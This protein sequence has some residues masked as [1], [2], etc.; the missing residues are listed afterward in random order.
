MTFRAI[1]VLQTVLGLALGA[2]TW[3]LRNTPTARRSRALR[4]VWVTGI[5]LTAVPIAVWQ[6]PAGPD[7]RRV[8]VVSVLDEETSRALAEAFTRETGI[9]CDIDPFAGGAQST[10]E[11]ISQGRIHP[12]VLLGGTV[13]I[14]EELAKTGKLERFTPPPDPARVTRY[15]DPI[16][17]WTP[18]YLGYLCLVYRPLPDLQA[19]PPE[20]LTLI[21]PRWKGRVAIPSPDQSGGGLVF[22]AT[23]LLRQTDPERGWEYMELLRENGVRYEARSEIPVARVAAGAMDLGVGWAH[24]VLRRIE[25]ERLPVSLRIPEQ[26]GYEVGGVSILLG[27]RDPESCHALV[28]FLVGRKAAEIQASVGMRVPLRGDVQ[29]PS[30]LSQGALAPEATAFYDRASV[31]RQREAWVA[32]WR[33]LHGLATNGG[34]GEAAAGAG[35]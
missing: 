15:D 3:A 25:R 7:V 24:D 9:L 6:P 23:Q 22:L 32:R 19:N 29:P 27:A 26:T 35:S 16:G 34:G 4:W 2:L 11:W 20:W 14:H 13:E 33:L 1:L 12:D 31:L 17:H 30:Y 28:R 5:A 8:R 21:N 18:L 10:V